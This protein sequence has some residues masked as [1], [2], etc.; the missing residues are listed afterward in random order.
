MST[1]TTNANVDENIDY[2]HQPVTYTRYQEGPMEYHDENATCEICDNVYPLNEMCKNTLKPDTK[3]ADIALDA[4]DQTLK[5]QKFPE[6]AL[7]IIQSY[8]QTTG[9]CVYCDE[10]AKEHWEE[11]ENNNKC[12]K[13]G[14]K[15]DIGE[16]DMCENR[17]DDHD[18]DDDDDG[19][20]D[21]DRT[22]GWR[23]F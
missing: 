23:S 5:E 11:Q 7:S 22:L 20:W 9:I 16:C 14:V 18:D 12:W 4:I 3:F 8:L 17:S 13:C 2:F 6:D 10:Y 21:F 19:N 15:C 1:A